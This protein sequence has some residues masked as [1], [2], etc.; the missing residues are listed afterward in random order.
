MTP[1]RRL[2]APWT[3]EATPS[4]FKVLDAEGTAQAY[5]YADAVPLVGTQ[6]KLDL[7]SGR[8]VASRIARIPDGPAL[9]PDVKAALARFIAEERPGLSEEEAC[10]VL[11][12]DAL[13][14]LGLLALGRGDRAKAAGR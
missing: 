6:A 12:R 14:G 10:R 7:D 5:V 2:P 11:V 4:G 8:R 9:D 1:P 3:V 13:I